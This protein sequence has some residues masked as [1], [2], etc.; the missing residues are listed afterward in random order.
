MTK[1]TIEKLVCRR[2][3]ADKLPE[4]L[5]NFVYQ[6]GG[7]NPF[8]SE[9]LALAL[10]DTGAVTV[11]R[12]ACEVLADLHDPAKRSLP[13]NLEGVIVSRIDE[14]RVETQLMLKVTSAIGG[15]FTVE[16]AQAGIPED[17]VG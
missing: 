8:H 9:E 7:G 16:T 17:D 14:L 10:R 15:D 6:Q 12:G 13:A 11:T 5:V 3:R 1:Q 4:D 2:L